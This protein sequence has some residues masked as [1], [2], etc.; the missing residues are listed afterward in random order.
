MHP[1]DITA[2]LVKKGYNFKT[3]AAN[4]KPPV[5]RSLIGKV[6]HGSRRSPRAQKA[7]ARITGFS[8]HELWPDQYHE[9]DRKVR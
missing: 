3:L 9:K 7:I 4:I 6:I 8:L 1:A 2:A 5:D